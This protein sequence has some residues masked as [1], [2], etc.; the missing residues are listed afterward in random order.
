[1]HWC[2]QKKNEFIK[3]VLIPYATQSWSIGFKMCHWMNM[4]FYGWGSQNMIA[5]VL[6][7]AAYSEVSWQYTPPSVFGHV[8][9]YGGEWGHVSDRHEEHVQPQT[10]CPQEIRPEGRKRS[11]PLRWDAV[12]W[13]MLIF[14]Y[15]GWYLSLHTSLAS[16][17]ISIQQLNHVAHP[18][19]PGLRDLGGRDWWVVHE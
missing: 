3:P 8:P 10:R 7:L 2:R 5:F 15:Y 12:F 6:C 1:M 11:S 13:L 19:R 9:G 17:A 4:T 16:Q 18:P 14:S